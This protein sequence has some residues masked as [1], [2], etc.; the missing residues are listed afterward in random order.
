MA[1]IWGSYKLK[2]KCN[3]LIWGQWGLKRLDITRCSFNVVDFMLHLDLQDDLF[4]L[5]SYLTVI[6]IRPYWWNPVRLKCHGFACVCYRKCDVFNVYLF[7][8]EQ[9]RPPDPLLGLRVHSWVLVLPGK[10]DILENFFIDPLSGQSYSTSSTCFLGIESVWNHENY[11]VNMQDC[12][13][14]CTVSTWGYQCVSVERD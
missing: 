1:L 14:G 7:L 13:F 8:Q 10:R 6:E 12:R 2:Q 9:G 4:C 5:V 3:A 11:W